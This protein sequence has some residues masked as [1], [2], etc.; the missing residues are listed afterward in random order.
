MTGVEILS[1]NIVYVKGYHSWLIT[2]FVCV[3]LIIGLIMCVVD[4]CQ[5]GFSCDT[6]A[7]SVLIVILCA[8]LGVF[9]AGICRYNTD[10][11]DH[12]EY[13]VTIDDSVSMNDFLSKY[14]IIDQED[15]IF[16]VKER[17]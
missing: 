16:T 7:M 5:Y 17:E 14:E 6:L 3:G 15:K 9:A 13:K 10:E 12:I 11:V 1:Q 4:W 2:M 8:V